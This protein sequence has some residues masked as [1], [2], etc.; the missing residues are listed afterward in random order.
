MSEINKYQVDGLKIRSVV[1]RR[2]LCCDHH[3]LLTFHAG[4]TNTITHTQERNL[5]TVDIIL[6]QLLVINVSQEN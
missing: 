2:C 1:R 3:L 5:N 6:E 4:L